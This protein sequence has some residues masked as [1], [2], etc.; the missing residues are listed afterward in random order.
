MDLRDFN[1]ATLFRIMNYSR[2]ILI[3]DDL[4]NR[5]EEFLRNILMANPAEEIFNFLERIEG[6]SNMILSNKGLSLSFASSR[7][8]S[9]LL[10]VNNVN[11]YDK[12]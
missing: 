3:E 9:I 12:W 8:A 4:F 7:S 11:I 2:E 10:L 1:L 6:G 5:I